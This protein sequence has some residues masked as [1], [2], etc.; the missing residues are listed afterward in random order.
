MWASDFCPLVQCFCNSSHL[1]RRAWQ[2][3]TTPGAFL[4]LTSSVCLIRRHLASEVVSGAVQVRAAASSRRHHP[5][6][7]R[8]ALYRRNER[9]LCL[10]RPIGAAK[11]L[12]RET[13][14]ANRIKTPNGVYSTRHIEPR[15]HKVARL[16]MKQACPGRRRSG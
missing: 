9:C 13:V 4:I 7:G 11:A 2:H 12:K 6:R 15:G 16:P 10:P 5:H 1:H 3:P 14:G 8:T